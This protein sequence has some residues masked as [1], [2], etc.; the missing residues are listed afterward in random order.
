VPAAR[1]IGR[2]QTHQLSLVVI[3]IHAHAREERPA[4]RRRKLRG[5]PIGEQCQGS[6]ENQQDTNGLGHRTLLFEADAA[7]DPTR[8]RTTATRNQRTV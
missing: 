1:L 5:G 3:A 6:D 4:W 8:D 2:D 7:H